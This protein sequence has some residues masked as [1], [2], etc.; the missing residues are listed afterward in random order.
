[1]YLTYKFGL[2]IS[3]SIKSNLTYSKI[4]KLGQNY[5]FTPELTSL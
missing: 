5:N 3:K 1:M 4:N 2:K